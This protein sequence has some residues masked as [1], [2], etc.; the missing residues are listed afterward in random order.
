MAKGKPGADSSSLVTTQI[1][2]KNLIQL[3]TDLFGETPVLWGRY[4]TSVSTSGTVEY[5][6]LK[7]N[8]ILRDNN[9]RVLP[10]ARQTKHVNG[11]QA[12][13]S[14][15]AEQ[16]IEDLILTF[17]E[18]HLAT[19]GGHFLLVLDVEGAPSLSVSYYTGWAQTV[20]AHSQDFTEGAVNI[21]PCV[22]AT[23]GDNLTW[24]AI[25][26][27]FDKGVECHGA[28]VARWRIRGCS[29]LLEFD[30]SLV[31]PRVE[32]PCQVLLWQYAD[33]CHGGNGFD[34]NQINPSIELQQDL[35]GKCILP[36]DMHGIV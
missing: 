34:C 1:Q 18:D 20:M 21:L 3:A 4:F 36:P 9:I 15:D 7:E 25:A 13:G 26:A 27:A 14:I 16:N 12:L 29:T 32:L 2:G 17:G 33:E 35:L 6:H 10:I 23:Q 5:R 31:I 8:Q 24:E 30:E 11:S 22:Y 28:W 19:Q